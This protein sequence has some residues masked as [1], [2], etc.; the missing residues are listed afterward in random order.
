MSAR[1][2]RIIDWLMPVLAMLAVEHG[3]RLIVSLE[4][5]GGWWSVGAGLLV[6][7]ARAVKQWTTE[8][9]R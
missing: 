9:H 5:R 6:V 1:A 8:Q 4:A 3:P 2:W 7:L